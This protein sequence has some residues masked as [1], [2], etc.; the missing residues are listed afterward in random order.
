[1]VFYFTNA[2]VQLLV[3]RFI[4]SGPLMSLPSTFI[5]FQPLTTSML[6][7]VPARWV[8]EILKFNVLKGDM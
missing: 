5:F 4:R 3:A 7:F 6:N 8:S 2:S 1:M